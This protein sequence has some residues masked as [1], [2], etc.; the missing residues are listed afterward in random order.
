MRVLTIVAAAL[1]GCFL[2]LPRAAPAQ[3]DEVA[4]LR[5]QI[6]QLY[7][8]GRYS[9]AIPLAQRLLG[10]RE[11]ALGPNHPDVAESVNN[12]ATLYEDQGRYADAEA[13]YERALGIREKA[14][15]PNHPDV[16]ISLNN[17]A[18]CYGAQGR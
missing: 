18:L 12:L 6:A 1:V 10:I 17:L 11:T 5:Q 14:L 13:L 15:G 9:D 8:Q 7:S 3:V 16:A 2:S 4:A